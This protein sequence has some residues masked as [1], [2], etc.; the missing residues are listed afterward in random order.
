MTLFVVS[1][2]HVWP[3]DKAYKYSLATIAK[4]N[5]PGNTMTLPVSTA[6]HPSKN[7][8]LRIPNHPSAIILTTASASAIS[9]AS[10][11]MV[12]KGFESPIAFL[13]ITSSVNAQRKPPRAEAEKT[14][15]TP[16]IETAVVLKTM[17]KTPKEMREMTDMRRRE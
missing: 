9:G 8:L 12:A 15:R 2:F 6:L 17:Q 10:Q 13:C 4:A 16:G 1:Y 11:K 14:M 7:S 3:E 5:V